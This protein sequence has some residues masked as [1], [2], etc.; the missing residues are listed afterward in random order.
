MRATF[1]RRKVVSGS[2]QPNSISLL[3]SAAAP[4]ACWMHRPNSKTG[5]QQNLPP[6]G[7]FAHITIAEQF[8]A[9]DRTNREDFLRIFAINVSAGSQPIAQVCRLQLAEIRR[10]TFAWI[11]RA[12][13]QLWRRQLIGNQ[14][15]MRDG[16]LVKTVA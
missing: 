11:V 7:G 9:V 5:R 8:I 12:D 3:C 15:K 13:Q 1:V 2:S 4:C 16:I 6:P 14:Q 10:R